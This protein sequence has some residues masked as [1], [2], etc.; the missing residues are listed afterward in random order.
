[1]NHRRTPEGSAVPRTVAFLN[2]KGGVGK[3]SSVHHLGGTLARRGLRVLVVDADPQ[4]SLTQ[5]L[6]GPDVAEA[7]DPRG[8]IAGLFDDNPAD[9]AALVRPTPFPGLSLLAGSE[10]ADDFDE[11]RPWLTGSRQFVLRDA[12]AGAGSGFDLVL[13]D[14]PPHVQF[15]AWSA[16]VAADGV[17]VPLQAEDYGAQGLKAI[18]RVIARVRAEANSGLT[19]VGYLVTMFNKALTVHV[20]YEAHLRRLFGDDAFAAV[21]PLAKDFKEAVTY[22]KPIS[23]YKPRSASAKTMGLIADEFLARLDARLAPS[24]GEP[25]RDRTPVVHGETSP[26]CSVGDPMVHGETSPLCSTGSPV[27][28]GETSPATGPFA[29]KS[30]D[31]LGPPA[32][33]P[34]RVA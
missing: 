11:P 3:T 33:E 23:D 2:K 21:V 14:C 16:L 19:L 27:V 24:A 20:T 6:L 31:R 30:V 12:L 34:R 26:P 1:V 18:N 28:H 15:W 32:G 9:P 17:V 8:T 10:A 13:I 4:A 29:D 22:R 7:L 25:P 5:G